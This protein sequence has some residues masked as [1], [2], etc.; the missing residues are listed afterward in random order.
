MKKGTIINIQK[1]S[2]HDGPGIRTTVFFKGC[3]LNCW[4]CHNPETQNKRHQIMFFKERCKGCG[5]CIK[6]CP[7]NAI[8]IIDGYPIIDNNKCTLCSKCADF[9]PNDAREYV[10]KDLTS[11]EVM[12]EVM[13][14]EMFYEDSG[15]GVT[16]SGGEPMLHV[17]FIDEILDEC[18]EKEVHTTLDTSGYASWESFDKIRDRIDLFLYDLKV[19]DKEKHKKY[20]GVDNTLILSNLKKLSKHGHNIFLRMPIVVGVN[21]DDKNIDD[22]IEFISKL[23]VLQVN[24]LPYHKMGM[25]KYK[26]LDMEYKLTGD[27]KPSDEYMN[28]LKEKFERAGIK[29][30][31]GG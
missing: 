14:D 29:V 18:R 8:K 9:C 24:L 3:P 17:D 21:D 25:E 19:M 26:R 13:K 23:N 20:I 10:G 15:G 31:I 12:D 30:K 1:Y 22:S 4:W 5:I 28:K 11:K 16:F 2:V 7:E 27:E 6:R